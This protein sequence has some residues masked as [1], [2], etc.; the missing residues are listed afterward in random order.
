MTA[1]FFDAVIGTV[2]SRIG[3]PAAVAISLAIRL[4]G[5]RR[6]WTSFLWASYQG[7]NSASL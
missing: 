5:P 3:D 6:G 4:R 1:Y 2:L 7:V